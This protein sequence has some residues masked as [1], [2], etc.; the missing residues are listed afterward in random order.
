M[1]FQT[2]II[3]FA[4]SLNEPRKDDSWKSSKLSFHLFSYLF[5]PKEEGKKIQRTRAQG[6]DKDRKTTYL[7]IIVVSKMT[8]C[9]EINI[10][11]LLLIGN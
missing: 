6:L 4:L 9:K 10:I 2:I 1:L 7:T 11:Y 5:I 3:I 8:Q